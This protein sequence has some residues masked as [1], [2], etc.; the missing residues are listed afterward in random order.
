MKPTSEKEL[1]E[2]VVKK[3][4]Y[5][6]GLLKKIKPIEHVKEP[7]FHVQRELRVGYLEVKEVEQF[8]V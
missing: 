1:K 2:T 3:K 5:N 6:R 8:A 4:P 7:A